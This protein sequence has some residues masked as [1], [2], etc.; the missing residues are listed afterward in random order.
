MLPFSEDYSRRPSCDFRF[1]HCFMS[2][3]QFWKCCRHRFSRRFHRGRKQQKAQNFGAAFKGG[4][5]AAST[6]QSPSSRNLKKKNP[7]KRTK[8]GNPRSSLVKVSHEFLVNELDWLKLDWKF[9]LSFS[10]IYSF[11][12]S[13]RGA[14]RL[15]AKPASMALVWKYWHILSQG[16]PN[17]YEYLHVN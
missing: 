2:L 6:P 10:S 9:L 8:R 7:P 3:W 15:W 1:Q 14:R 4:L 13:C 12:V 16:K 17:N 11:L 5:S